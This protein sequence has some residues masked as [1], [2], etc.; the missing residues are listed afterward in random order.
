MQLNKPSFELIKF[1]KSFDNSLSTHFITIVVGRPLTGKS[2][3]TNH[4]VSLVNEYS[5]EK[6]Q[7]GYKDVKGIILQKID[8]SLIG[9][10]SKEKAAQLVE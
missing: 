8:T 4:Y 6:I 10:L 7:S 1:I 9:D 2:Y 3:L 5:K